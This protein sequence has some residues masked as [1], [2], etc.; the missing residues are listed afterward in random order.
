MS[1]PQARVLDSVGPFLC[2][3]L[4]S[5]SSFSFLF[6]FPYSSSFSSFSFLFLFPFLPWF[7][8]NALCPQ[9]KGLKKG[10]KK[11]QAELPVALPAFAVP[12]RTYLFGSVLWS[13]KATCFWTWNKVEATV[14]SIIQNSSQNW[15]SNELLIPST[16]LS[17]HISKASEGY[18]SHLLGHAHSCGTASI[19]WSRSCSCFCRQ[20]FAWNCF[21]PSASCEQRCM[22]L[23][24][25]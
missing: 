21:L 8:P 6:L 13:W 17:Q 18:L 11:I 2:L 22:F 9:K 20:L 25:D 1:N 23:I 24:S 15:A 3:R 10:F 7:F 14:E 16:C 12:R 4:S 19:A 5:F